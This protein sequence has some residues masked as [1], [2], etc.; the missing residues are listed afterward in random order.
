MA[1]VRT[2]AVL[3]ALAGAAAPGALAAGS[4]PLPPHSGVEQYVEQLPSA[5]GATALGRGG[6]KA[7]KLAPAAARAVAKQG[8]SDAQVLQ[9]L[10]TSP[11]YGAP[12]AAKQRPAAQT[13]SPAVT[14]APAPEATAAP[15]QAPGAV[16]A[17]A[18]TLGLRSLWPLALALLA[19]TGAAVLLARRGRRS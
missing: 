6:G 10:A 17:A 4:P 2:A 12:P 15:P 7:S 11:R 1:V 9:Q 5:T 13:T 3:V 16:S 18:T 8:G 19:V 14:T